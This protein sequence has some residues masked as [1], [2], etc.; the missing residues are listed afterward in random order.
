VENPES[1]EARSFRFVAG[2]LARQLS[3]LA[4]PPA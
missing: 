3:I 2:E 1:P 4:H